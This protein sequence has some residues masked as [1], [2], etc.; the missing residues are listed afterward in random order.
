MAKLDKDK[1]LVDDEML[2][3]VLYPKDKEKLDINV[4]KTKNNFARQKFD[5]IF[6]DQDEFSVDKLIEADLE[7]EVPFIEEQ[8]DADT[9]VPEE[10]EIVQDRSVDS[11]LLT[12]TKTKFN[13]EEFLK[14]FKEWKEGGEK[15]SGLLELVEY[16][17]PIWYK[18]IPVFGGSLSDPMHIAYAKNIVVKALKDYDPSKANINVYLWYRLSNLPR[19]IYKVQNIIGANERDL[20]IKNKLDL[21]TEEMRKELGRDPSDNE[22]AERLGIS[23]KKLN[24]IRSLEGVLVGSSFSLRTDEDEERGISPGV[25]VPEIENKYKIRV[26]DLIYH[27][28]TPQE[29]VFMEN[30]F[31]LHGKKQKP[32]G[33]AAKAAGMSVTKAWYL[34]NEIKQKISKYLK[35]LQF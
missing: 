35:E 21:I 29:Q 27:E 20:Q 22:L 16:T 5:K 30:F 17:K 3:D 7:S 25:I 34:S 6:S 15:Q 33:E 9:E 1:R 4:Q 12:K 11:K 14:K 24:A 26:L 23:V 18:K 28:L 8:Y 2:N 19:H 10:N 32:I 31:G 13:Q